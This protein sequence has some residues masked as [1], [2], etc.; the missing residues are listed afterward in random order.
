MTTTHH[1]TIVAYEV[2]PL[3]DGRVLHLACCVSCRWHGWPVFDEEN[4]R[5]QRDRHLEQAEIDGRLQAGLEPPCT[6]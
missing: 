1:V 2:M 3:D 5:R 6:A 4:A